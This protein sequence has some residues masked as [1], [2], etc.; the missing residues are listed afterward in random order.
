MNNNLLIRKWSYASDFGTNCFD[1]LWNCF[2]DVQVFSKSVGV[3]DVLELWYQWNSWH[4]NTLLLYDDTRWFSCFLSNFFA[5]T[6]RCTFL[7]D[8]NN[9]QTFGTIDALYIFELWH[10]LLFFDVQRAQIN[11]N[12]RS[13]IGHSRR[14]WRRRLLFDLRLWTRQLKICPWW[15][16]LNNFLIWW[17]SL[18]N[19]LVTTIIFALR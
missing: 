4:V 12:L 9:F 19:F 14:W 10:Q 11:Q 16:S 3:H 13:L 1:A 18:Y 8:F 17:W 15:W 2:F 7:F 6:G 5:L